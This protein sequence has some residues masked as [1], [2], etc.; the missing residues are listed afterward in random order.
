MTAINLAF[1]AIRWEL[2]NHSLTK[3][4]TG[5]SG[6]KQKRGIHHPQYVGERISSDGTTTD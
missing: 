2:W 1:Q 4:R 6:R 5:T 3:T